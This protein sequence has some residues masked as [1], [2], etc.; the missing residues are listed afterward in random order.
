M[1]NDNWPGDV[2]GETWPDRARADHVPDHRRPRHVVQRARGRRGRHRQHPA[3]PGRG[4]AVELGHDARRRTS[5]ARTTTSSTS[6]TRASAARRTCCCA[7]RSRWR[8]TARRSTRPST[9][10]LRTIS[11][12][13]TP[14]GIPGFAENI[15]EYCAY[16]PEGAQAAYDEWQAAGNSLDEPLPIQFNADAGHEPVADDHRREPGRDR[17]RGRARPADHARRTSASSPTGPACFC[18]VGL[19]SPTTRRTTTSCTTCSTPTSLG[20][21]QLRLQQP[22]VRRP[23]RR[24]QG[25]DRRRRR[26]RRCST[27]PR[28]SC[29]TTDID[30]RADQLVPRRLRLQPGRRCR[31]SRRRR[32]A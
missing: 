5:S 25:D 16:D 31:T 26:R 27:R 9:T 28:S 8:S 30:G 4:G 12:G 17:H 13:I 23:R 15:C 20:R 32:S 7:R 2:N 14:P 6:A 22:G 1:R 3:G 11:T 21:Q 18:R 19:V 29:S 24:G 10:A